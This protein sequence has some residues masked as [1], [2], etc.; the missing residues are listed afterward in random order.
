[1]SS[2]RFRVTVAPPCCAEGNQVTAGTLWELHPGLSSHAWRAMRH[3]FMYLQ[4]DIL[5]G[6]MT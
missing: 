5:T 1:M 3:R 4:I 6:L 2:F